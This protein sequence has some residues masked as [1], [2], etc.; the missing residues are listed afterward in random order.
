MEGITTLNLQIR[1]D[2]LNLIESAKISDEFLNSAVGNSY[3]DIYEWHLDLAKN[4][5]MNTTK[6]GDAIADGFREL[7]IPILKGK[8]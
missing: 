5:R 6:D 7:M 2:A 4:S 1:P 3:G 8:M